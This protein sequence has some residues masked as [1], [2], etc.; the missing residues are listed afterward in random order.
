MGM[1]KGYLMQQLV[2]EAGCTS[3]EA[4][5]NSTSKPKANLFMSAK[6]VFNQVAA[7]EGL[8]DLH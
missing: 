3:Q 4:H 7:R 2:P 6:G 5:R 8:V 1:A